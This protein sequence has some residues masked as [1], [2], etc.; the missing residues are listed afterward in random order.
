MADMKGS[1]R[2]MKT[3][4]SDVIPTTS[5]ITEHK[6][7]KIFFWIGV[8]LYGYICAVSIEIIISLKTHPLMGKKRRLG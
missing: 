8:K 4:I 3:V 2:E 5:K 7:W 1:S 6:L